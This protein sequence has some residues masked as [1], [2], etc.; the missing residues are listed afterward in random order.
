MI[1]RQH[2][3]LVQ[4]NSGPGFIAMQHGILRSLS[5]TSLVFYPGIFVLFTD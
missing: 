5:K 4:P 2:D 1:S 3:K